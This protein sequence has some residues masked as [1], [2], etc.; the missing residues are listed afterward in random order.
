MSSAPQILVIDTQ[1]TLTEFLSNPSLAMASLKSISL[2]EAFNLGNQGAALLVSG[3][4]EQSIWLLSR[5][6]G[7]IHQCVAGW[8]GQGVC[9]ESPVFPTMVKAGPSLVFETHSA[10]GLKDPDGKIHVYDQAWGIRQSPGADMAGQSLMTDSTCMVIAVQL[11][12]LG[13]A[14]L[15]GSDLD[16]A[17]VAYERCCSLLES[18]ASRLC[19]HHYGAAMGFLLMAACNNLAAIRRRQ[20]QD[21]KKLVE[22]VGLI[23]GVVMKELPPVQLDASGTGKLSSAFFWLDQRS[24]M[25][26]IYFSIGC[27]R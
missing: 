6:L 19:S 11:F 1:Q 14:Y 4:S 20:G 8:D 22:K 26:E 23:H 3:D 13:L 12:N 15:Q 16:K 17:T 7:S 24:H 21:A 5:A 9:K 10:P 25:D 27:S 18:D 2:T